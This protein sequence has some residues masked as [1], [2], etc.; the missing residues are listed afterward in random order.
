VNDKERQKL[1]SLSLFVASSSLKKW[2]DHYAAIMILSLPLPW[3]A[4]PAHTGADSHQ[5]LL[6]AFTATQR[7]FYLFAHA[8]GLRAM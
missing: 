2:H 3:I 8:E 1:K 5:L 6:P 4:A 7:L